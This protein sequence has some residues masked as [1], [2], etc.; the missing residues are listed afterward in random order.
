MVLHRSNFNIPAR[1]SF[2]PFVVN[3][4][5]AEAEIVE[6]VEEP[7]L[8]NDWLRVRI[9]E[10][11][12]FGGLGEMD[13]IRR[14]G[15]SSITALIARHSIPPDVLRPHENCHN[16]LDVSDR[17][18][19]VLV[20]QRPE[21]KDGPWALAPGEVTRN[22]WI[23]YEEF[24]NLEADPD[25][26]LAWLWSV[27][28]FLNK[29][30]LWSFDRGYSE[31]RPSLPLRIMPPSALHPVQEPKKPDFV[32]LVPHLL[33][34]EQERYRKAL[35]PSNRL[36]WLR[37]HRLEH[38]TADEYPFIR[39]RRS[40]CSHTIEATITIDHI[41]KIQSGICKRCHKVFQKE[42]RH[43]KSYCSERCFNAAGVQRW[44]EK[45][46]KAAKKGAGNG[47]KKAR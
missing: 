37:S 17:R 8:R 39:V 23:M 44:R 16:T 13:E 12:V 26:E 27:L 28:K 18:F 10:A 36:R 38:E 43:K 7:K 6:W 19:K 2:Q 20:C 22:A 9:E 31:D 47:T 21:F 42:T 40:C 29:W 33:K 34:E 30:G 5:I 25:P 11:L 41:A 3:W 1:L 32:L 14:P 35:L 45:Q 4:H 15:I 46:R 24:R